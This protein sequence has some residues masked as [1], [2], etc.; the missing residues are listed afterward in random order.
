MNLYTVIINFADRTSAI[1]QVESQDELGALKLAIMNA[2]ALEQLDNKILKDT[3]ENFLKLTHIAMGY[4]GVW[5]WHH[6]NF[7]CEAV[8]EIYG[9]TIVQTDKN[10]AVRKASS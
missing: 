7:N 5:Q 9:G 1:E 8:S 4:H 2:E 3:I 6:V 10:G